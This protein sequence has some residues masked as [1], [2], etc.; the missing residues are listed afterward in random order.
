[1]GIYDRDYQRGNYGQQ[2]GF[3]IGGPTTLTT[4]LVI[5][6]FAVYV[7]QLLTKPANPVGLG[8]GGWFTNL[9]ELHLDVLKNPLH[10]F[11]ILTYG[12][13]HDPGDLR[14]IIF[15]MF[16]LWLFGR[17]VE[18]RYGQREYL[19]FFL[20]S[21]IAAG[22]VWILG[23]LAANRGIVPG[24][25]MLGASGG[26]TAVVILF[27]LNF[28]NR[29]VLLMFVIP[30]PMWVAALLFVAY[31]AFGAVNR[32]DNVAFTAHLGGALFALLYYQ[33]GWRLERFL[34][35]GNWLK[36]LKPKPK[37]RVLDPD[38]PDESTEDQ[39]DEILKKIQEHGRDSLT[40][41]ERRILEEASKQYQKRR[42]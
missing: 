27:A 8:D 11:Q 36:Q 42:H 4:K 5:V 12:F 9:F 15:N 29:Q 26:V 3:N 33:A 14:H 13:L 28:P 10:F 6:M 2:S 35:S 17:D 23:E 16:G 21:V 25:A 32:T 19:S 41:R 30:M 20:I 38:S 1:M 39:V 34:P 37:L 22:A 24:L 18:Y 31:D 40:R 7:V